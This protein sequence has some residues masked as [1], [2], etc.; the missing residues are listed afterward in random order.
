[1]RACTFDLETIGDPQLMALAAQHPDANYKPSSRWKPETVEAKRREHIEKF[2]AELKDKAALDTQMNMIVSAAVWD[3]DEQGGVM[4][5]ADAAA[6]LGFEIPQEVW[7]SMVEQMEI[8]ESFAE[9]VYKAEAHLLKVFW[10]SVAGYRLISGFNIYGFDVP[11]L[12]MR[13]V[14]HLLAGVRPSQTLNWRRY[15]QGRPWVDTRMFLTDWDAFMKGK[16]ADWSRRIGVEAP[17][18]AMGIEG[19]DVP[20][21]VADG[22]WDDL[23]E[24]NFGDAKGEHAL[25]EALRPLL[26]PKRPKVA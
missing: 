6:A 3:D 22:R 10:Q 2:F 12:K 15:D 23:R 26:Y 20:Q 13:T 9:Q 16:L 14:R 19:K 1:M 21:L 24:Y 8:P 25:F 4:T 17:G 11:V 5:L 18:K 7:T